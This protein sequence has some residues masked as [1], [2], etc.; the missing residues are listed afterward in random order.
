MTVVREGMSV[1]E[2]RVNG[3]TLQ[4]DDTRSDE[5]ATIT[6]FSSEFSEFG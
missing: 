1:D 3:K 2:D 5:C 6:T 4:S